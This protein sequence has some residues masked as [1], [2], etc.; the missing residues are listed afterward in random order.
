MTK[1]GQVISS[2][3]KKLILSRHLPHDPDAQLEADPLGDLH[4]LLPPS[5]PSSNNQ[6]QHHGN[7]QSQHNS[8]NNQSQLPISVCLSDPV[9]DRA[10]RKTIKHIDNCSLSVMN[11]GSNN[12][13]KQQ[14]QGC[15]Y[16]I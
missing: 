6:S 16:F 5:P 11:G 13:V 8:N 7:N 15:V 1:I 10:L 4:N 3:T 2:L 12:N 14:Q 9:A